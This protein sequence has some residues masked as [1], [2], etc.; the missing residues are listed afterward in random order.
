[1]WLSQ[2]E[3]MSFEAMH[4]CELGVDLCKARA[5]APVGEENAGKG[6]REGFLL[7]RSATRIATRKSAGD[8]QDSSFAIAISCARD[9]SVA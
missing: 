7:T 9:L 5:N 2:V 1:M 3:K 4:F 6:G 8:A